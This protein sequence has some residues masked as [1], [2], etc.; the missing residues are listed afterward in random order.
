MNGQKKNSQ[1]KKIDRN[2][3]TSALKLIELKKKILLSEYNSKYY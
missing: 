2:A 1:L 3:V